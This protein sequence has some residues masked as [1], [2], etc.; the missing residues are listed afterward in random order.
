LKG[1]A[2]TLIYEN[3][4]PKSLWAKA[5]NTANKMFLTGVKSD[6]SSKRHGMNCSMVGKKNKCGIFQGP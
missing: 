5:S 3:D 6:L 1:I 4:L 2:R